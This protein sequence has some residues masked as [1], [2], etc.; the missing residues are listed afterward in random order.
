MKD[1][2]CSTVLKALADETRCRIVR[3]LLDQS[4]TVSELTVRTGATQ[5]NVSKHLRVLREAGVVRSSKVGKTVECS[6]EP[7]FRQRAGRSEAGLD[8]GCCT[9]RF[10]ENAPLRVK[11][12]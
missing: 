2:P 12:K 3:E 4:L 6:L 5:Y 7:A 10:E 8:F 11:R 9:F 1:Q